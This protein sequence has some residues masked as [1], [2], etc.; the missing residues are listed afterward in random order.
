M[1]FVIHSN[2]Q[3]DELRCVTGH[4]THLRCL[5]PPLRFVVGVVRN[6]SLFIIQLLSPSGS[7]ECLM[8]SLRQLAKVRESLGFRPLECVYVD[9]PRTMEYFWTESFPDLAKPVVDVDGDMVANKVT[10]SLELPH[11]NIHFSKNPS[12]INS[13]CQA[14]LNSSVTRCSIDGEWSTERRAN[15]GPGKKSS[16]VCVISV[17]YLEPNIPPGITSITQLL[18]HCRVAVFQV[19]DLE[20]LPT[21]LIDLLTTTTIRKTGKVGSY[22]LNLS[23]HSRHNITSYF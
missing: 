2:Q 7:P 13:W 21:K 14:L 12:G 20:K 5:L 15:G 10:S 17:S 18:E 22:S 11:A 23:I 6:L 4:C 1:Y 19:A 16:K 9:N 3:S 8:P